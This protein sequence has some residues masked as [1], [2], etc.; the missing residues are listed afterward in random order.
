MP[1]IG[2]LLEPDRAMLKYSACDNARGVCARH[3]S[4]RPWTRRVM[5]GAAGD[6]TLRNQLR[7]GDPDAIDAIFVYN[8]AMLITRLHP[9]A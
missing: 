6:W 1:A 4:G 2:I 9:S 3:H 8:V 7:R 5:P